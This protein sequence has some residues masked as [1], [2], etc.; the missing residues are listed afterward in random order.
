[1]ITANRTT[2][3]TT[4]II[5]IQTLKFPENKKQKILFI[6]TKQNEIVEFATIILHH[7]PLISAHT[8]EHVACQ[9]RT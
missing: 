8:I 4:A 1:M 7:L 3:P 9:M 2:P 5:I 6:K